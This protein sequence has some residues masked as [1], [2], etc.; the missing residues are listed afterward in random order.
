M[1]IIHVPLKTNE[2]DIII[3]STS[4]DNVGMFSMDKLKTN[5]KVLIIT[6][7][8][9]MPLYGERVISSFNKVGIK[10]YIMALKPGEES[11]SLKTLDSIYSFAFENGLT[12]AGAILALG[13]GVVG[14]V[15]G[16]AAATIFRGIDFIQVPTSLLAQV[17]SSVGGKVAINTTY[18]KN[19]VGAFYQPKI[20][21]IDPDTLNTLPK[22]FL[23]DGMAEVIKYGCI[24]D[25]VLFNAILNTEINDNL[26]EKIKM[27][28][29]IKAEYVVKDEKDTGKRM[30]LNFGH[31]IGHALEKA[32]VKDGLSHGFGVFI[33]MCIMARYGEEIGATEKGTYEKIVDCGKKYGLKDSWN[34]NDIDAVKTGMN[35]DKKADSDQITIVLIEKIGK[36]LLKKVNKEDFIEKVSKKL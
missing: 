18:G 32:Y 8:N 11:K 24:K 29:E 19:L 27:C 28:L 2:Y 4:L 36:A 20:V 33:G 26:E 25:K 23:S 14:D 10:T 6:D 13:G 12:R 21:I 15:A 9:V 34:I 1:T 7:E 35:L 30:E 17:D 3:E 5:A 16:F 31:T 22:H